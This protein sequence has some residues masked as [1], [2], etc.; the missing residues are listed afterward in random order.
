MLSSFDKGINGQ[1]LFDT[2][3]APPYGL[4][5]GIIPLF[6]AIFDRC[7]EHPINHYF[8]SEYIPNPDGDHYDLMLKH[9]KNCFIKY[10]EIS[11]AKLNTLKI[12]ADVFD[13]KD[14][15]PSV[16]SVVEAILR[17]KKAVPDYSKNSGKV[18]LQEKKLLIHIDSAK[19]PDTLMFKQIPEALDFAEITDK[20]SNKEI[21]SL[22]N[23]LFEAKDH[24]YSVYPTLVKEL[25]DKLIK[26]VQFIQTGCLGL[27]AIVYKKGMNVAK[28]YQDAFDQLPS[29]IQNYP[30]NKLTAKFINRIRSFDSS[31]HAQYFV[32]TIG[33]ALT[34]SNP[35]NWAEKGQSLFE[36]NLTKCLN[37]IEMVT[38]LMDDSFKG[39]SVIAF[40]N[41]ETGEKDYVRLGI[42][43]EVK[44]DKIKTE[45]ENLLVG[46]D[47][48]S[49]NNLLLSLL[50]TTEQKNESVAIKD[51]KGKYIE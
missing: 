43:S 42:Y 14:E 36:T 2:L 1:T 5:R 20:T 25:H 15:K 12:Y 44:E 23:S 31:K 50:R 39:Q 11:Q 13:L 41:K 29:D 7:L 8:D 4:R 49:R 6:I 35:R 32:E 18:S 33:D 38:E 10:T 47:T 40:I 37:E 27:E 34:E 45:L 48:K 9:P 21:E 26:A 3:V 30:F 17:W 24:I 46:L 28:I 22:K 51:I 19:E 16:S